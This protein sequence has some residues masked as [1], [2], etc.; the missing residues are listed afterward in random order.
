MSDARSNT[1][2]EG[3]PPVVSPRI[4]AL[5]AEIKRQDEKH[6]TFEGSVLGRS[7][8]AIACIEDEVEEVRLAW[9]AERRAPNWDK[10]REEVL[11]VAAVAIRA[12]RDAL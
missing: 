10:T 8:L 3:V 7:R 5:L 2:T 12:L 4:Y 1:V 11:Q 9:L 6:G